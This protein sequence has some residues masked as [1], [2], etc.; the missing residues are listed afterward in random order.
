MNEY[1]EKKT[2]MY[3]KRNEQHS[4][5]NVERKD[6]ESERKRKREKD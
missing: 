3:K 4:E 5:K 6:G 2:N 1:I